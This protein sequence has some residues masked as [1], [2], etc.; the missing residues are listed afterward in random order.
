MGKT[1]Q[2]ITMRRIEKGNQTKLFLF[3]FSNAYSTSESLF[4]KLV[5]CLELTSEHK[6]EINT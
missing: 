6:M 3:L 4:H 1:A 2:N 5:K